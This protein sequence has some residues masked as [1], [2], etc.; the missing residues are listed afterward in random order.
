MN[1]KIKPFLSIK[2]TIQVD[3]ML[4]FVLIAIVPVTLVNQFYYNNTRSFIEEKV[5]NYN[6]EIVKQ[7][8]RQLETLVLQIGI[9][10]EQLTSNFTSADVTR[11][12]GAVSPA[13]RV[14]MANKTDTYLK[15]VRRSYM[16]IKDI[17]IVF[18]DGN[19]YS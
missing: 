13:D 7:T 1:Q 8:G 14:A 2:R 11:Y 15:S 18:D 12:Y 5:K 10:E 4:A 19:F 9:V 17:F 16:P 6:N 3:L